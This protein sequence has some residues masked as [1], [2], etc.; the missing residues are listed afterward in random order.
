MVQAVREYSMNLFKE[1]AQS[2]YFHLI[3]QKGTYTSSL[4]QQKKKE[5]KRFDFCLTEVR[6][7]CLFFDMY[8]MF[9]MALSHYNTRQAEADNPGVT[10]AEKDTR[11]Q[12]PPSS[13]LRPC[14]MTL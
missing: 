11:T 7:Y 4:S 13:I 1:K 3:W 6:F 8:A 12:K 10:S 2:L 9:C 5:L 14:L